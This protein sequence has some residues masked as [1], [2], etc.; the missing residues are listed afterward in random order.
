MGL[1]NLALRKAQTA[2]IVIGLMLSTLIISA[3]FA[4]G[5]TVGYSVT[6]TVYDELGEAD[7]IVVLDSD[8]AEPGRE[9][10]DA[11]AQ[12]VCEIADSDGDIEAVAGMIQLPVPAENEEPRL[13]G[14]PALIYAADSEDDT[15]HG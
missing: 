8:E 6:N 15:S 11:A 2:L 12:S 13:S 1:R 10:T 14:P 3:A 4:T 5:D 7:L 9:L